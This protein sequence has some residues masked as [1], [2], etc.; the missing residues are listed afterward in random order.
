MKKIMYLF[1]FV[2]L[3]VTVLAQTQTT[4]VPQEVLD[5]KINGVT[6]QSLLEN[7]VANFIVWTHDEL[8]AVGNAN[9]GVFI[10][11]DMHG[12]MTYGWYLNH[13]FSGVKQDKILY[14]TYGNQRISGHYDDQELFGLYW[15]EG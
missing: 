1:V 7:G 5:T 14:G 6:A 2:L 10:G 9:N 15:F 12:H 11:F 13:K 8:V 3:S 4:Q